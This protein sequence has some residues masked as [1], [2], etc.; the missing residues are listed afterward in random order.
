MIVR[1][2]GD[3]QEVAAALELRRRVFCDEQGVPLEAERD[4]RD[5]EALHVLALS[6]GGLVGTCRVLVDGD[7]ARLGRMAVAPVVRGR[8]VGTAVLREAERLARAAGAGRMV[9]HA[10]LEARGVYDRAGYEPHGSPFVEE[11]IEH[12]AMEKDLA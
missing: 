11:G 9:L 5:G 2:A 8:G 10:Q 3:P 4:G 1:A 7:V 12:V 6:D